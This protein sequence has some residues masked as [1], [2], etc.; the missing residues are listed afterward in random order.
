MEI[1]DNISPWHGV[2]LSGSTMTENNK[3]Y[4]RGEKIYDD[5]V[6]ECRRVAS[7]GMQSGMSS[8]SRP[9]FQVGVSNPDL[10][11]WHP[12]KTWLERGTRIVGDVFQ[13]SNFYNSLHQIY[14]ELLL[15]GTGAMAMLPD[16]T[17]VL[18]CRP[19]SA[20]EY[21]MSARWDGRVDQFYRKIPMTVRQ[22]VGQFGIEN[23]S[24]RVRNMHENGS[25]ETVVVVINCVAEL[26]RDQVPPECRVLPVCSVYWEEGQTDQAL[27]LKG[28][29]EWPLAT[30]RWSVVGQNVWGSGSPGM[31]YL[32]TAKE[33]HKQRENLLTMSHLL[34]EPP[35]VVPTSLGATFSLAPGA[36][37]MHDELAGPGMP[38]IRPLIQVDPSVI[39][40]I[41]ADIADLQG[42]FR[43]GFFNDLFLMIANN[44]TNNTTMQTGLTGSAHTGR[45]GFQF[46]EN[47]FQGDAEIGR[48]H[49]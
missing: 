24:R 1:R 48:A 25:S 10:A 39:M 44:P 34:R 8:P 15:F 14:D 4:K 43:S 12:V 37:V 17:S 2:G 42:R 46:S 21:W 16:M 45:A 30:P 26:D 29:E 28:F 31:D 20:G 3:G 13:R 32:A 47:N 40:G 23:C 38:Q 9:W 27:D 6:H 36:M 11:E 19:F 35:Y 7:A 18:R 22:I 5:V 49:V 41:R 33:L